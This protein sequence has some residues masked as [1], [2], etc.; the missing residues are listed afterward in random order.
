MWKSLRSLLDHFQIVGVG[1]QVQEGF[2]RTF[3]A[4]LY[5]DP[6]TLW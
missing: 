3:L 5:S 2:D 1:A 4:Y 6:T